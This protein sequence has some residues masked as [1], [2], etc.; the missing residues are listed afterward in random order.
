M[1]YSWTQ[2]T[3][4]FIASLFEEGPKKTMTLEP[5]DICTAVPSVTTSCVAVEILVLVQTMCTTFGLLVRNLYRCLQVS[6]CMS[7]RV[8]PRDVV[9]LIRAYGSV[10]VFLWDH[11]ELCRINMLPTIHWRTWCK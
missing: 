7:V 11:G 6:T 10:D 4:L 1:V 8:L 9:I 5:V 3:R 2:K